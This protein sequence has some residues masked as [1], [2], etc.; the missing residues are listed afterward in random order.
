MKKMWI[1]IA[2]VALLG[3]VY[4]TVVYSPRVTCSGFDSKKSAASAAK[5]VQYSKDHSAG[6]LFLGR[7]RLIEVAVQEPRRPTPDEAAMGIVA[8]VPILARTDTILYRIA[9]D[10]NFDLLLPPASQ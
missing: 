9:G 2:A 1:G 10:C 4:T 8:V 6:G 7:Y 3:V 5:Y